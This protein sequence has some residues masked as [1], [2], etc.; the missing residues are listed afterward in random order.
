MKAKLILECEAI[1]RN[2][3]TDKKRKDDDDNNYNN[4]KKKSSEILRR[5]LQKMGTIIT[6]LFSASTAGATAHM[7]L[8]S[9]IF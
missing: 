9:A 1:E 8:L 5:E 3:T 4:F 6:V 2:E 7:I